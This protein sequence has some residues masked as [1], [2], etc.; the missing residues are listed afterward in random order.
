MTPK[1]EQMWRHSWLLPG[2]LEEVPKPGDYHCLDLLGEPLIMVRAEDGAVRVFSA[3]C[4]HRGCIVRTGDGNDKYLACPYHGWTY[5]L[6]GELVSVPGMRE[7]RN[8]RKEDYSLAQICSEIWGGFV[9]VNFDLD[10]PPLLSGFGELAE[11]LSPYRFE[12]MVVT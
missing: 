8:F 10:C 5:G 1:C 9:F 12:E 2:R 6:T 11:R 3:V 4:R 7:A